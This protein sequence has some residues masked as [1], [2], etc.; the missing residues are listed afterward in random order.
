M[1]RRPPRPTALR[2]VIPFAL[3]VAGVA[4]GDVDR[5]PF[6]P[7]VD[8][9]LD[10]VHAD[11]VPCDVVVDA[12]TV[13]FG[14]APGSAALVAAGIEAMLEEYDGAL[15]RSAW[16]SANGVHH[17]ELLLEDDLW[18]ALEVWLSESSDRSVAGLLK[19]VVRR[20]GGA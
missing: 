18:G 17:V 14:L 8:H 4:Q 16:R 1:R 5:S 9:F 15:V 10:Q 11:V 20:R 13:C 3:A 19:Y 2:F 12:A 6:A 7:I